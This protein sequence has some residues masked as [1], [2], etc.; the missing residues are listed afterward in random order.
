MGILDNKVC[1]VTGAHRG[2]GAAILQRFVD[3]G[4]I[5]YANA[6]TEGCMD[7]RCDELNA[8]GPGTAIPVYFDVTDTQA[9]KKAVMRIRKEQGRWDVLVNNAGIMKDV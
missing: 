6:R 5:V 7:A 2:I 9:M 3:E 8:V 4:A 1:L